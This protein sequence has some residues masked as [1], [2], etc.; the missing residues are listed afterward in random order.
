MTQNE[1]L[2]LIPHESPVSTDIIY[3]RA[4]DGY[5]NATAL[6]QA[7]GKRIGHYLENTTTKEFIRE[8]SRSVGIPTDQL[9]QT[10]DTG[11]NEYRGTWVHPQIAI[12]LGQWASPRFAVEVS[13]WIF[14][15]MKGDGRSN[16]KMPYH[17]RRYLINRNKIP[18]THFSMLDNMTLLLLAPLEAKN[19]I[20]PNNWMPDI[21]M[22]R[23]FSQWLRDNGY[24]PNTYPTYQHI[25]DDGKRPPV[26]ARLYPNEILTNFNLYFYNKWLPEKSI[27]YLGKKEPK[28]IPLLK[29]IIKEIPKLENKNNKSKK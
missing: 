5:V 19:F 7:C 13:K 18:P 28:I 16:Y 12:N 1:Q 21:S 17:I 3:Q 10:I 2:P 9:I 20:I 24:D 14:D 6:C 8:L 23:M 4:F 27:T 25:F 26:Q 15:W 11:V 22:G 29:E